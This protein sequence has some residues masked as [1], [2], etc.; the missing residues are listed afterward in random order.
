MD[1]EYLD[2]T[3]E[4]EETSTGEEVSDGDDMDLAGTPNAPLHLFRPFETYVE[5]REIDLGALN[6]SYV[7]D[8]PNAQK[9]DYSI[10]TKIDDEV[11]LERLTGRFHEWLQDLRK[12][13]GNVEKLY[14]DFD[15]LDEMN[16]GS[17]K[18]VGHPPRGMEYVSKPRELKTP[19]KPKKAK[20]TAK[21]VNAKQTQKPKKTNKNKDGN[22][23]DKEKPTPRKTTP[24]KYIYGHPHHAAKPFDSMTKFVRHAYYLI[25][26]RT[27]DPNDYEICECKVCDEAYVFI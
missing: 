6:N 1:T 5:V 3:F 18:F 7:S 13:V 2:M 26:R 8:A 11:F 15:V 20:K 17:V 24:D 27:D 10:C 21:T 25:G 14:G 4:D 9:P 16:C 23:E 12:K 19:Y 22:I